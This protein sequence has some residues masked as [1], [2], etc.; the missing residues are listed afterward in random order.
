MWVK[1]S[2]GADFLLSSLFVMVVQISGLKVLDIE[3]F[4][5]DIGH[6]TGIITFLLGMNAIPLLKRY[7]FLGV[8]RALWISAKS[9]V[10]HWM[11]TA[12]VFGF[13]IGYLTLL[14]ELLQ[15]SIERQIEGT[16]LLF[17]YSSLLPSFVVFNLRETCNV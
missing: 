16:T 8:F 15:N 2:I 10:T 1:D 5:K 4:G 14:L 13:T 9:A 3:P 12:V 7:P 17:F 6:I 11:T